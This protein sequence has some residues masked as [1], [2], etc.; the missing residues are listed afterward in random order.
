MTQETAATLKKCGEEM[1]E[2]LLVSAVE[3]SSS[4]EQMQNQIAVLQFAALSIIAHCAFNA[5]VQSNQDGNKFLDAVNRELKEELRMMHEGLK[6][7]KME[8]VK[9]KD[10]DGTH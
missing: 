10:S 7:G 5:E 8:L 6:D 4:K 3:D 2:S 1:A 9:G